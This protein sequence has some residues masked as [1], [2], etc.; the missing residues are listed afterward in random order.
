MSLPVAWREPLAWTPLPNR[1]PRALQRSTR[2]LDLVL[3][4]QLLGEVRV[5]VVGIPL[6]GQGYNPLSHCLRYLVHRLA[7]AIPVRQ[8]GCPFLPKGSQ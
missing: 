1:A 3:L 2:Y 7:P 8:S 5:I 4:F 6:L